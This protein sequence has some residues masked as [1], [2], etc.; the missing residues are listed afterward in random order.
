MEAVTVAPSLSSSPELDLVT[1][2][3][4]GEAEAFEEV[5]RQYVPLVHQ[6]CRRMARSPQQAEDWTQEVFLRIYRHLGRFDGRST[7]KTWIY[8]VTLNY[9]RSRLSRRRWHWRPL[10]EQTAGD[11]EVVGVQLVDEGAARKAALSL[12]T[13]HAWSIRACKASKR[14]F[15]RR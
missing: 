4:Y 6:L 5:Y 15:G 2:H 3:R 13:K 7:L 10:A 12:P 14:C 9:C 11:D 8:R 1:R